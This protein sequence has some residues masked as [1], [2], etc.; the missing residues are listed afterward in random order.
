MKK[1]ELA[2][3]QKVPNVS[4]L[5]A[6]G[7]ITGKISRTDLRYLK[8]LIRCSNTKILFKDEE[9]SGADYMMTPILAARLDVLSTKVLEEWNG[10]IKLRVTE[11][12]DENSEHH[13][14][15]THYEGRAADLTT[16][17]R[18]S[19]KLGRLAAL[20]VESGFDW[21]FY[22]NN[23]HVHVSVKRAK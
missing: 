19:R 11:A 15:S 10:K 6:V 18:D 14:T 7:R 5:A 23:A 1:R 2:L 16:S 9:H 17:D 21:V 4:E 8:E 20:A 13:P 12:W 22:E 3:H